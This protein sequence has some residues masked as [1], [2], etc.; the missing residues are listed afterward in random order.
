MSRRIPTVRNG[1]LH[2]DLEEAASIEA[3]AVESLA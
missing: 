1:T 2:E 3:I